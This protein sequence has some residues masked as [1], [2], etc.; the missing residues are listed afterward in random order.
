M[1]KDPRNKVLMYNLA[2]LVYHAINA[3]YSAC[4][5]Y[6]HQTLVKTLVLIVIVGVN[7]FGGKMKP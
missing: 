2:F 5:I 4:M 1:V 6:S 3:A 7:S